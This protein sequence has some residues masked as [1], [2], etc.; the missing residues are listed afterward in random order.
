MNIGIDLGTT[1]SAL[2]FVEEGEA[3]D[4]AVPPIRLLPIPQYVAADRIEP[5]RTLPSFLLLDRERYVGLYAREQGAL[6]PTRLVYL[7]K[8]WLA[9]PEFDRT[10][11]ILPWDANPEGRILSPV[12]ASAAYLEHLRKAWDEQNAAKLADQNLSLTVPAS[13]DEEAR[14][15]TV[16]AARQAG[17]EK[18]TL[19]EEPVAAFYAWVAYHLGEAKRRLADGQL[20]LVVDVGGGTTDFTLVRVH[21]QGDEIGFTRTAVGPHLLLG[22]DNLDLTLSWL[23]E[24]KLETRLSLSQRTSLLRQCTAVKETLLDDAGPCAA[25]IRVAGAGTGLVAGT[26]TAEIRKEEVLEVL[27]DGFLA[28]CALTDA[29]KEQKKSLFRE[30]GLPYV[31]DPSVPRHLAQFLRESGEEAKN[32]PGAVLFNGGFFKPK[33]AR[34]RLT[35]VIEGWF[36]RRPAVLENP[37]L[38]AAVAVG[39]AYH[40]Y[41]RSTGRGLMVRGGLPRA[42]YVEIAS[43]KESAEQAEQIRTI[44]IVPRG[45]EEGAELE[46]DPGDL[47]L[48]ANKPVSFRLYSSRSRTEDR[49]GGIVEFGPHA[50]EAELHKHAPLT[51]VIRFGRRR[52]ERT[53]PVKL[54]AR[55]TEVGTLELWCQ[56]KISEHRWRLQFQV[57]KPKSETAAPAGVRTGSAIS[58]EALQEA[59]Q[60]LRAVFDTKREPELTPEELP[61]RLEGALGVGKLSWPLEALRRLGS[62]LLELREGRERGA[63]YEL[64]FF[65]LCGF[66]LRPGFGFPGDDW[67]VEQARQLFRAGLTF[68]NKMQNQIEW[69]IFW[70]RVA[71]GMNRNQQM[72]VYQ[73]MSA[74]LLPRGGRKK[75]VNPALLRQ[76]WRTAASLELL[77]VQTK[78]QLGDELVRRV[79]AGDYT[80]SELWCL[81]RLGARKLLYGPANQAV[82]PDAATRWIQELLKIPAAG[83][84]LAAMARHT[85][86]SARDLAPFVRDSVRDALEQKPNA[87]RLLA[88]VEGEEGEESRSWD[89]VFGEELPAGL[90][91]HSS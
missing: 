5:R 7:A 48:V 81:S 56:S 88:V 18:L 67:R 64:R 22:G 76:M 47:Q 73:R 59:E 49:P 23:A 24:T 34:E 78:V 57:R 31:S 75:R 54:V 20:V 21:R 35:D 1:N 17:L 40:S 44:C 89:Q 52:G 62:V 32:G 55:L 69:H 72:D 66:C 14:E 8:S 2:A 37:E 74:T 15:L 6:T 51:T 84:A 85:G 19:L 79:K 65:N 16:E 46:V 41:V 45:A 58:E 26:R 71:G 29:P 9:N 86:D 13:F 28:P 70:G 10:E 50:T 27:L 4:E 80:E 63:N 68:G 91:V 36:G 42:Y 87:A 77:P 30:L 39:A 43:A 38:D 25:E 61:A 33:I 3:S 60:L 83:E 11:K 53:V 90:V 82:P 12:E